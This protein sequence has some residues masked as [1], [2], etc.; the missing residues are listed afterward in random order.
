MRCARP[1]PLNRRLPRRT[2]CPRTNDSRKPSNMSN[3][4]GIIDAEPGRRVF[5][6][7]ARL[8]G[9]TCVMYVY[10]RAARCRFLNHEGT[11]EGSMRGWTKQR[12]RRVAQS[13]SRR[14]WKTLFIGGYRYRRKMRRAFTRSSHRRALGSCVGDPTS[15]RRVAWAY[16]TNGHH[17]VS[18]VR[19]DRIPHM[20]VDAD[21][22]LRIAYI[23]ALIRVMGWKRDGF[24]V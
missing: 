23:L 16:H 1:S 13:V 9:A 2:P 8:H 12:G 7:R 19:S 4:D 14:P 21:D 5:R 20:W 10:R 18:R 22:K 17:H 3:V 15:P 6:T 11:A 24:R